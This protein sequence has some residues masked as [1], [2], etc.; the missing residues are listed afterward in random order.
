MYL[1]TLLYVVY[2]L[3]VFS[4]ALPVEK[5]ID[6]RV[7]GLVLMPT[8]QVQ[9][10]ENDP[11]TSYP[12]TASTDKSIMLYQDVSMN[13]GTRKLFLCTLFISSQTK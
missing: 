12:N 1:K 3:A 6:K 10:W 4:S 8:T 11:D 2:T 5:E 9:L 7:C 13:G